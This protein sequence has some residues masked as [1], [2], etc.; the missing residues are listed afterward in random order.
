MADSANVV[1]GRD[2]VLE[3]TF[4]APREL[5]WKAWTEA[6][7]VVVWWGPEGFTTTNHEMDVRPGGVWRFTMHGPD[8]V[9]YPNKVEFIEVVKPERLVY[10]HSGEDDTE[11]VRFLATIMFEEQNGI[12]K[13]TMRSTFET[14]EERDRVAEEYGAIEGGKQTLERL[15]RYLSKMQR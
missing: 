6:E 8:G 7:R 1:A 9:D 14:A 2:I 11:D 12:T 4:D 3:R 15:G 13:V 5:V 10:N